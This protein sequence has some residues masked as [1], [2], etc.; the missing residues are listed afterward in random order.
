MLPLTLDGAVATRAAPVIWTANRALAR[1]PGL[2]LL[3][4]N[5]ELVAT[6]PA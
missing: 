4:T 6:S 1:I 5:L 3:A 2:N